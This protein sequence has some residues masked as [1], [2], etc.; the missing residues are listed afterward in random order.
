MG[1]PAV[2][3][4]PRPV[5]AQPGFP[6]LDVRFGRKLRIPGRI[7]GAIAQCN[8][9]RPS[10]VESDRREPHPGSKR[11]REAAFSPSRVQNTTSHVYEHCGTLSMTTHQMAPTLPPVTSRCPVTRV[12]WWLRLSSWN[13]YKWVAR[14]R[15][16]Q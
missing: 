2:N 7:L 5:A 4:D 10:G 9:A 14:P 12:F 6:P 11:V 3:G 16:S 13:V 8:G 15:M 1:D